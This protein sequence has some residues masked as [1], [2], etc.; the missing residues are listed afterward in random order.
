MSDKAYLSKDTRIEIHI[1]DGT[2]LLVIKS[3]VEQISAG[4]I[5]NDYLELIKRISLAGCPIEWTFRP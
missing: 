4:Q 1:R 2:E 3:L 5:R